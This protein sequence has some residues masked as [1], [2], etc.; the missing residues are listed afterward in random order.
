MA[1][2]IDMRK[3]PFVRN[4][5]QTQDFLGT[6]HSQDY[7]QAT[8]NLQYTIQEIEIYY[9]SDAGK[10]VVDL[11]DGNGA[12]D[13]T[14]GWYDPQFQVRA[15]ALEADDGANIMQIIY[16]KPA[17]EKVIFSWATGVYHPGQI[18]RLWTGDNAMTQ[19]KIIL[20]R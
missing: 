20:A 2:G 14:E 17:S 16:D 5:N 10:W 15:Y 3:P 11:N 13:I 8:K 4:N 19:G 1:Y 9:N 12:Q 18:T 6:N 7:N